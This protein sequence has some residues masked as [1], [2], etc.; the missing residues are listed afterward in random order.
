MANDRQ[1]VET[2][3]R[4]STGGE[5]GFTLVEVLLAIVILV[6][7]LIGVTNLMMMASLSNSR[8]A[9][10][11]AAAAMAGQWMD[12]IKARPMTSL[13]TLCASGTCG[14]LDTSVACGTCGFANYCCD[15]PVGGVGTIRTRWTLTSTATA[16]PAYVITVRSEVDRPGARQ[17]TRAEFTAFRAQ[18][19]SPD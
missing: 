3:E 2:S 5:G 14:S 19:E 10:S 11:T 7:G 1:V 9:T 16:L 4:A 8:A 17:A 13:T 15:N 18:M 6:F 12:V